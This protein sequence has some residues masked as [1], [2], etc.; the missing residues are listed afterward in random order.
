MH[1]VQIAVWTRIHT[2]YVYQSGQLVNIIAPARG[3]PGVS[4]FILDT[5][6]AVGVCCFAAYAAWRKIAGKPAAKRI[7]TAAHE[8]RLSRLALLGAIWV[9]L[10]FIVALL[11]IFGWVDIHRWGPL[12]SGRD[13]WPWALRL[14]LL[15]LGVLAPFA[16]TLLG[17]VAIAQIK[18]SKGQLYGLRLAAADAL[19]Y[20]LIVLF[21]LV[22]GIVYFIITTI[23]NAQPHGPREQIAVMPVL[24]VCF[25]V[26]LTV[27]VAAGWFA[28]RSIVRGNEIE[29]RSENASSAPRKSRIPALLLG[30]CLL[31]L[32][33]SLWPYSVQVPQSFTGGGEGEVNRDGV[34]VDEVAPNS[35]AGKA[36]VMAGDR[37]HSLGGWAVHINASDL[38]AQPDRVWNQIPVGTYAEIKLDRKNQEIVLHALRNPDPIGP[39]CSAQWQFI[40]GL[41]YLLFAVFLLLAPSFPAAARWQ[42]LAACLL[43]LAML[44]FMVAYAPIYPER[45]VWQDTP[46]GSAGVPALLEPQFLSRRF[47]Y[48]QKLAVGTAALAL[49]LLGVFEIRRSKTE[50]AST[51]R[52]SE[53]FGEPRAQ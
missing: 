41:S 2:G 42:G 45:A 50:L 11:S 35:P 8:P 19:L 20:P 28:W 34:I 9:P 36:G 1:V 10:F 7:V 16:T 29:P 43:G 53:N 39:R 52:R 23:L 51:F 21:L 46:H 3:Y 38:S 26:G 14:T 47:D 24:L 27:C 17:A 32:A 4:F 13:W 5:I 12:P 49:L 15:L 18:R 48:P 30:F 22:G 44:I 31:G 40:A 37:L 6:A 25:V 33:G